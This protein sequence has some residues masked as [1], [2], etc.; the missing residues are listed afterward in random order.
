M[1][2]QDT[3]TGS[4]IYL[5][6]ISVLHKKDLQYAANDEAIW[7]FMPIS[8]AGSNFHK[9]FED[10]L[11]NQEQG[12]QITYVVRQKDNNSVLGCTAYYDINLFHRRLALGFSWYIRAVWGTAINPEAKMLMLNQ[13]FDNWDINRVEISTDPNNQRS[14]QAIL[15]LGAK[16]EGYLREHMMN[17]NGQL[18]DTVLFSM[19]KSEWPKIK[20]KLKKRIEFKQRCQFK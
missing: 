16:E 20:D 10:C 13:A 19:L 14:Y 9:W 6:P 11:V 15:A 5:E 8:A 3:L 2:T 1:L 4:V 17:H 7:Q 12:N 18:T